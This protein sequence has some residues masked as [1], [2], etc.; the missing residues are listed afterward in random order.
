MAEGKCPNCGAGITSGGKFC[1]FCGTK[2]PDD[3]QRVEIEHNVNIRRERINRAKV[4]KIEKQAETE[5]E[6]IRHKAELMKAQAELERERRKSD[7]PAWITFIV[8][9]GLLIG[10][11]IWLFTR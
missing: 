4:T 5:Q 2:L 8:L 7:R 3:V 6:R 1:A 9:F 10:V 11:T